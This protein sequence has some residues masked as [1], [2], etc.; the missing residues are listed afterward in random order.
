MSLYHN[1]LYRQGGYG[2]VV[3]SPPTASAQGYANVTGTG[4]RTIT[5]TAAAVGLV[6]ISGV[7]TG[8][9]APTAAAVGYTTVTG[10]GVGVVSAVIAKGIDASHI[11]SQYSALDVED[12]L[13]ARVTWRGALDG[14]DALVT[15]ALSY[16]HL[17]GQ[18]ALAAYK[19]VHGFTD[20]SHA[21]SVYAVPYGYTDAQDGL[22]VYGTSY[23]ALDAAHALGAYTTGY[24]Y[25]DAEARLAAYLTWIAYA[26]ATQSLSAYTSLH[27]AADSQWTLAVA[28]AAI[29]R[30]LDGSHAI[31]TRA[32]AYGFQDSLFGITAYG[33]S[34]RHLDGSQTL[35]AYAV[36]HGYCD[37]QQ[38][39]NAP[40]VLY[41]F[42]DASYLLDAFERFYGWVLNVATNAPSRYEGFDFNSLCLG[43][44]GRYLGARA[45]G[46]HELG[47]ATDEGTTIPWL[48]VSGNMDFAS[49]MQKRLTDA[50]I[51]S[52]GGGLSLTLT[53]DDGQSYTYALEG[54]GGPKNRKT[55]LG[56]GAKGRYWR[57]EL[58]GHEEIAL[59]T[60]S[61]QAE[62]LSRRV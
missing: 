52:S 39:L 44:G 31:Q 15:R 36:P 59:D 6:T 38:A 27:G 28:E 58:A 8:T 47:G 30:A 57:A 19:E 7:V 40:A 10:V 61:F 62:V 53:A 37:G 50:Y 46:I 25:L 33:L 34:Y 23:G 26:D 17:D 32:V 56:R 51:G 11:A 5:P 55:D 35:N 13:T 4:A 45:D 54:S 41:A 12:A 20:G 18:D 16:Q 3:L 42:A 60:L 49:D 29:S 1:A 9:I 24:G 2:A 43:E 22:L 14:Q 21:L 48:L